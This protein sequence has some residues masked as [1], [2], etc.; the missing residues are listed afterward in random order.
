MTNISRT[1]RRLGSQAAQGA[2]GPG[3]EKRAVVSSDAGYRLRVVV[4]YDDAHGPGKSAEDTTA[5]VQPTTPGPPRNVR[6]DPGN[7]RVVLRWDAAGTGGATIDRY[8]YRYRS[9]SSWDD[10]DHPWI[11]VTGGGAK[12]V[13][14]SSLTNCT[15]YTFQ[16]RAHNRVDYGDTV[17]VAAIPATTPSAPGLTATPGDRKVVLTW[18]PPAACHGAEVDRYQCRYRSGS[19]WT[20]RS[21]HTVSGGGSARTKTVTGLTNDSTYTFQLRARNRVGY[22][23][24]DT[25]TATPAGVPGTPDLTATGGYRK[26]V[27]TWTAAAPNGATVDRYEYRYRRGL[28]WTDRYWNTAPGGGAARTDT[29]ESLDNGIPYTFQLRAHNSQG[30]GSADT[31]TATPPN[32]SPSVSG[33]A[34]PPVAEGTQLVGTYTASDPDPG[35]VVSWLTPGGPD[36]SHFE[37]KTPAVMPGSMPGSRRELHFKNA[38]DYE[39]R[40]SYS[41]RVRVRDRDRAV[42]SVTVAVSVT[43]VNERPNVSGSTTVSVP[44]RTKPVDTYTGSDPDAGDA[45]ALT[46]DLDSTHASL[47]ELKPVTSQPT[48]RK[49]QFKSNPHFTRSNASANTKVVAVVVEDGDGLSDRETVTVTITDVDDPGLVTVTPSSPKVGQ[50]ATA[51]LTD[52]DGGISVTSW[53]WVPNHNT[54]GRSLGGVQRQ[55]TREV[56]EADVGHRL[57]ATASYGDNHGSG[58]SAT[59]RTT[60]VVQP[61]P[62]GPPS[63]RVRAGDA[64]ATLTWTPPTRTGGAAIDR[65]R[66]KRSPGGSW[67]NVGGGGGARDTTMTGLT[68]GTTYTFSV[69]ARNRAGWGSADSESGR[70][71]GRPGAPNVDIDRGNRRA[72]LRWSA[73]DSNGAWITAYEFKRSTATSWLSAGGNTARSKTIL[74]L[75]NGTTYTFQIRA[76]NRVGA[77]PDSSASVTPA[78]P[79]GAPAS[80]STDRQGGHGFMQL[81]WGTAPDNGSPV[82]HYYYR[83]KKTTDTNWRGWYRRLG[84][85]TV[86]SQSWSNFDDG[87]SYIFQVRARNDVGYGSV[88]QTTTGPLGPGG[89]AEGAEGEDDSAEEEGAELMP[90]GEVPEPREDDI[91]IFDPEEDDPSAKP[92]AAAG[93]ARAPPGSLAVSHAPNP[94]NASTVLRVDLPEP[95]RVTLTVHNITGQVV[96]VVVDQDLPAG[97][98]RREWDGRDQSGRAAASGLYL[99]RLIAGPR[100]RTGKLALIR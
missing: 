22:G 28:S 46:W 15:S 59:G 65:Y 86:R 70:P 97:T 2:N 27:L 66:V 11:E 72:T 29:V 79:P 42:D 49:V 100:V 52:S 71:A 20:G 30:Y 75:T 24:A 82:L 39:A 48:K 57:Q 60:N 1:W 6:A 34:S 8:E 99:Y 51:T 36:G 44:E 61:I 16:V 87:A 55:A 78:G 68:N 58:K 19:S 38:P 80:L 4:G 95:A 69:S 73:A 53:A 40:S 85:A 23:T 56:V 92:V 81:T 62:P 89:T 67:T 7:R 77:G 32:R 83:Y 50:T 10:D 25:E 21:W 84:G 96:A 98:H 9:G 26:V 54:N 14:V 13:T 93:A 5:V 3:P 12:T 91:L 94:F 63:L 33:P 88:A 76:R 41:V 37:L 35:D 74:S 47:F 17:E 90:E 45:A 31:E 64:Q 18:T 43:D